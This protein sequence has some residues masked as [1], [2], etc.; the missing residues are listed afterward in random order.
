[1]RAP[2]WRIARITVW[3]KQ[4][5]ITSRR[6]KGVSR[7][8]GARTAPQEYLER[9]CFLMTG[10]GHGHPHSLQNNISIIMR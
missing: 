8:R 10:R 6:Q 4:P 1:M 5:L 3:C 9:A 7:W 2:W